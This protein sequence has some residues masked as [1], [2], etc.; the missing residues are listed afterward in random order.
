M[1]I[2]W[3]Y[4]KQVGYI[5]I[6]LTLILL[7]NPVFPQQRSSKLPTYLPILNT[8]NEKSLVLGDSVIA[9]RSK[10]MP[11]HKI[12]PATGFYDT[13]KVIAS[14]HLVTRK[15]YD[16]VVVS[17]HPALPSGHYGP[18]EK[19]FSEYSGRKIRQ[20]TIQRLP[21][22]GSDIN[23]PSGES[24]NKIEN[25]LNKTHLNTNEFIVRNNLLFKTG[26]VLSPLVLSDNERLLRQLPYI[27]DARI[28][29]IPAEGNFVDIVV[30]TKDVYSL[31]ITAQVNSIKKGSV[32]LFDK[33]ILGLGHEFRVS[34]PFDSR[35]PDSPGF[36]MEYV[37]NN[38]RRSFVN[39]KFDYLSGLGEKTYGFALER[40]LVSSST[41]YAGGIS[42]SE[43]KTSTDLD[44][45]TTRV[46]LNYNL[47]DYW[48]ER[49]FLLNKE[50]VSRLIFGARY[51]NNNVFNHPLILP[52]SYHYLQQYKLFLGTVSFS[53]QKYFKTNMLY[54]YG[55]TEDVPSGGLA[56]ITAGREI[57]EFDRRTYLGAGLS[58]GKSFASIGHIYIAAG[59][60]SYFNGDDTEQGI[61]DI[62]S[63]F[64]S[65]LVYIG[66][67]KMRNF[68]KARYTR[69]FDRFLDERLRFVRDGGFSEF[70]NDSVG[71]TQRLTV[72]FE[73]V[74]FSPNN[75]YGFRFAFFTFADFGCLFGTNQI[76][77]NGV[78]LSSVGVGMRVRSDNLLLNTIQIRLGFYPNLPDYSKVS[79]LT[80][81]EEQLLRPDN[82]DPGP[83]STIIY[84]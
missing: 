55:R 7:N 57:N 27:E 76:V 71:G 31:G 70:R 28:I 13:L 39:L 52:N 46:P 62:R 19:D 79:Y 18:S 82:F 12:D 78:A 22:F 16:F 45:M 64:F 26:D 49:S 51:T 44:T 72:S 4:R 83:P 43:M 23:N 9:S 74:I 37:I 68:V 66:T 36:G 56:T 73:S 38:I 42:I 1:L 17:D 3:K 32:T 80:F 20:I 34:V 81:S 15:L 41:K 11:A 63:S 6:I 25:L 67:Y 40:T 59:I 50:S 29:V 35:L 53:F 21:V 84:R 65:N 33:N 61:F 47:Q 30:L 5:L 77:K 60:A 14:K 75:L 69:G 10:L 58:Y 8:G 2:S 48:I 54:A 24:P